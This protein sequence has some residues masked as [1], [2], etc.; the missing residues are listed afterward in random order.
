MKEFRVQGPPGTG[1]THYIKAQVKHA[2][3]SYGANKVVVCSLTRSA[4]SHIAG[5]GVEIP[6]ENIGTIHAMAYRALPGVQIAETKKAEFNDFCREAKQPTM[7]VSANGKKEDVDNE[8]VVEVPSF[9]ET[10]GDKLQSDMNR[11]RARMMPRPAWPDS[12]RAFANLWERWKTAAGVVDFTD[13]LEIALRDVAECPGKPGALF[14]D[15]SQDCSRLAFSLLRKWG[16]KCLRFIHVGDPDQILYDWAGVDIGAFYE[17]KLPHEQ[18]RLLHKSYRVPRA[19]HALSVKWINETPNRQ[20]IVYEPRDFEGT[21]RRL[22]ATTAVPNFAIED[23]KRKI[24]EGKSCLFLVSCSYML[25]KIITA[26]RENG[27]PFHNPYR[28][29][30]GDWNPLRTTAKGAGPAGRLAAFLKPQNG[31]A[32][33]YQELRLWSE[34]LPARDY[35]HHGARTAI[36][37]AAKD[38]P[39]EIPDITTVVMNWFLPGHWEN[40]LDGNADWWMNAIDAKQRAKLEYPAKVLA[41]NGYDALRRSPQCIVSTI[42]AAKGGE[43]DVVYV[44][45]DLSPQ[46]FQAWLGRGEGKEGVR[47]AYYVAL[48]R[49]REEVVLCAP[50]SNMALRL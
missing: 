39:D 50:S 17:S 13:L 48:T 9:G 44:F 42:H 8:D 24:G 3:E 18:T 2:A 7:M 41:K 32:W 4:A 11:F 15:E 25:G 33:S 43:S 12:V 28:V 10:A 46:A 37:D 5:V 38:H 29:T 14:G 34:W 31:G 45:P 47:R 27:I 23:A 19:V 21:I 35:L 6:R 20:P 26:L 1:K 30:R 22:S 36:D 40:I 49:A 16:E